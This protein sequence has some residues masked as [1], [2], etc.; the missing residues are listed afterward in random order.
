MNKYVVR[1]SLVWLAILVVVS[2]I[3]VFHNH[4]SQAPAGKGNSIEPVATGPDA[5]PQESMQQMQMP[6][7]VPLVPLQL[8]PERMQ[9]IGVKIGA[10]EY[11]NLTN[12]I[13][14]TGTVD[15]NERLVTYVQIRFPGYIRQ[16]F[17]NATYLLVHKGDP[18]FT[19]YSPE[20]LQTQK[21][22]LLAQ[23]S[24]YQLRG[25]SVDGVKEGAVAMGSAAEDRLRQW[26]IPEEE[27]ARLEKTGKP[28]ADMTI[29]SPVTGYIVERNALPN[30]YADLSTRL[31][32]IADL[33]HVW[34]DAQVYQNEIGQIREGQMAAVTVDS[35]PGQVFH[36][37][38]ESILP[39]VDTTTRTVKVRLD[40]MNS[41]LK[42]KPGMFVNVGLKTNLGRKLVVPASAVFQTGLRQIAFLDRGNGNLEPREISVGER[43][44]DVFVITKGLAPNDHIVTSANFLIDSESQ[45]E[46]G[47]GLLASP[48]QQTA[49]SAPAAALRI[50]FATDPNPPRQ[51]SGNQLTVMLTRAD[52]T[53]LTGADVKVVFFMP[54]MPAMNMAAVN[55][56]AQLSESKPGAYHGVVSLPYGGG[57]QVTVRV[58][59]NGQQIATR[60][61]KVVAE[62]GM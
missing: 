26:A 57:Y 42:L 45:L 55:A 19:V 2:A 22:Y 53:P 37:K 9:S 44:G 43:V 58:Q 52:G 20:L 4:R 33:S 3:F 8:S 54:A 30:M 48:Q 7:D 47:T 24:Q 46:A 38:I 16:V 5:A 49:A 40:V 15:V 34:V 31:F 59:Q 62:G 27:I 21:E 18:L 25:S 29:N 61:L 6:M 41:D 56:Q 51:G 13:R 60:Q 35:Y 50:D 10:V 12:D 28:T 39:Q 14:A 17:A 11:R 36:A 1:T 32:T 23:Q